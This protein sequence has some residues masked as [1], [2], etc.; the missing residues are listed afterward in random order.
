MHLMPLNAPMDTF[1]DARK[2]K[3]IRLF[4]DNRHLLKN[5]YKYEKL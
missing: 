5:D 1:L 3:K 4:R 2:M